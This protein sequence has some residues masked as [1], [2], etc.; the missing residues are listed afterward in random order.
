M[1]DYMEPEA[2]VPDAVEYLLAGVW[3]HGEFNYYVLPRILLFLDFLKYIRKRLQN[4]NPESMQYPGIEE[5]FGIFVVD[6]EYEAAYI[7]GL[8]S[9]K[10]G[11][12]RLREEM[13]QCADPYERD[14]YYPCIL[15]DFDRKSFV[16]N[17]WEPYCFEEYVPENWTS[18]F[19]R[20][21]EEEIPPDKHYWMNA[22]GKSLFEEH[23]EER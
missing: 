1:E 14:C 15:I 21:T 16:S 6:E 20:I 4:F 23:F 12:E 3:W 17:Y 11:C 8:E 22:D 13:R 18:T 19:R 5:R 7:R 9:Y 10:R 2:L